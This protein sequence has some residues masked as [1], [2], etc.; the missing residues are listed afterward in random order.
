MHIIRKLLFHKAETATKLKNIGWSNIAWLH[1][2]QL[3]M[4]TFWSSLP[5][6][7]RLRLH[8][9]GK[10]CLVFFCWVVVLRS[11]TAP[12]AVLITLKPCGTF[13]NGPVKHN[14]LLWKLWILKCWNWGWYKGK[15]M[16]IY[17]RWHEFTKEMMRLVIVLMGLEFSWNVT[18]G[19]ILS[20]RNAGY[21]SAFWTVMCTLETN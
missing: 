18:L 14:N 10:S 17:Q 21:C 4:N 8:L 7:S 6:W 12:K 16:W 2:F 19:S 1:A 3:H 11:Y 20:V 9:P 5:V 15:Y 13:L